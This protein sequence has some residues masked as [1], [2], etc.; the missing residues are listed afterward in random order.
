ML[1]FEEKKKPE[2]PEK[3]LSEQGENQ[4]QT[5]PTYDAGVGNRTW[6]T[7]VGGECF[8]HYTI[9]LPV[10]FVENLPKI[11]ACWET[12][13]DKVEDFLSTLVSRFLLN[14]GLYHRMLFLRLFL[15]L[16][17]FGGLNSSLWL[18]PLSY[19]A[20]WYGGAARS[21]D[22]LSDEIDGGWLLS[23]SIVCCWA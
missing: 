18:Y 22:F 8:N 1:V 6:A 4:Q 20:F 14:G 10:V 5:Q 12:V 21:N 19:S 13:V 3:N 2:Y 9:P 16:L 23:L 11:V 17:G 15:L 7:L